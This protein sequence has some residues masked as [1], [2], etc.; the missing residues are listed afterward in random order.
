[1]TQMKTITEKYDGDFQPEYDRKSMKF[2]L[3]ILLKTERPNT[4]ALKSDIYAFPID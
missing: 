4:Y 2:S 1:M 3:R